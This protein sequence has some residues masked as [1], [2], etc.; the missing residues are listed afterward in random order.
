M[1]SSEPFP[2]FV[3]DYLAYLYETHPTQAAF[4]GVHAHDDLLEDLSRSGIESQTRDLAAFGRR[5]DSIDPGGL[6]DEERI[7]RAIVEANVRARLFDL[8][9][10]RTWERDPQFYADLLSS[11]LAAQVLFTY[12]SE[13]ERARR[14]HAKLRQVPRLLQAARENVREP[15]GLFVKVAI[16]TLRGVRTFVT[17]DLPRA[18]MALDDIRL[19]SDLADAS[20]EA[21]QAIDAYVNYLETEVAPRTKGSFRLGQARFEQKLRLDE[22]LNLAGDRLLGIAMRELQETQEEFRKAAARLNGGDPVEAWR[23]AKQDH[24]KPGE[25][26]DAARSQVAELAEFVRRQRIVTVPGGEPVVVAPTP[27]FYRW[28][29]ASMWTPGPFETRP[30]RAFYYL[31]DVDPQWPDDRKEEHLREF[32][33][34]ALWSISIHE[35]Y[36]GHFLHYQHLRQVPSK[37]RRSIMF[38]PTSFV[39]GWAHY[40]EQMMVEAGFGR[41]DGLIHLGQ[42]AEALIRLARFVVGIRLHT[43]DLSVEQGVRFFRDEAFME[44]ASARREAERGTFD[45]TYV[46]YSAGKLMLLKLRAD[47]QAREGDKYALK[48]FHDRLLGNGSVPFWAHRRLMLG[49]DTG[50]L[51]E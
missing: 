13:E 28:T 6:S 34:G 38:A 42:L 40:C 24:P 30:G 14:V 12:A 9:D 18:F 50:A 25:L 22:G 48:A 1:Y 2:H 8:E 23:R 35:V 11:S 37:V 46:V 16:E 4:D 44:E 17:D 19:L 27:Q 36:P 20:M 45:P 5:L 43:E 31:T 7:D 21:G 3:D 51:L 39:E 10:V 47:Y 49:E 15:A 29:F 32:N 33:R 41:R 26:I